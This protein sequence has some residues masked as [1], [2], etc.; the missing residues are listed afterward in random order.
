MTKTTLHLG[1]SFEVLKQY[2]D[3]HFDAVVTD[4]PYG[5][6]KEP[7]AVKMLADW[8]EI[9]HHDVKGRGFMGKEWDA[10]VPQ[11]RLWAE[12]YRVLKPGGHMLAF[13]G[14]R[15]QDLMALSIRMAGFEIRDMIAWVYG[16]GFPKSLNVSKAIDKAAGVKF[17][18]KPASGVGFMNADGKGGYNVT[19][20]QL[21]RNGE[22]TDAARQ[23]EGWGTALKPALEP[24]TVARKP[25][26]GTVAAN[27]LKWNTGALNID[28]SRVPTNEE[29][30]R[31]NNA[32]TDGTSYVVQKETMRIDNSGGARFPANLIHDGSDEVVGLFPL[33]GPSSGRPRNNQATKSIARSGADK[34]ITS[35]G[36]DDNGGSAARFF[37]CAKAQKKDRE[38]GLD[39]FDPQPTA[40]SNQAQAELKR[41]NTDFKNE[42]QNAVVMRRNT[43]PTVKPTDLMRYLVRLVTPTGGHVLDPFMGSGT[44]GKAA[45]LEGFDFT[46]V[47]LTEKYFYIAEARIAH[48]KRKKENPELF[49][50][51]KKTK[52]SKKVKTDEDQGKLFE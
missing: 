22:S 12:V 43:H 48:A 27:V 33:T 20:N 46:G 4:P 21:E 8:V 26:T 25:L 49:Q 32:R 35:F 37:Y 28:A 36:Y 11:P 3:N 44:T 41:G 29:L 10:F 42:N 14:T 17:K 9:G 31:N 5:F 18:A 30:G 13:S 39:D 16:S 47:D 19:R 38:E 50:P 45:V 1:D 51:S 40:A 7:D 6:G 34:A 2:P 24:I 52:K 23:W 15:T